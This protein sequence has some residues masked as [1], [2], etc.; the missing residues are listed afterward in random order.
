MYA[1]VDGGYNWWRCLQRLLK[2]DLDSDVKAWSRRVSAVRKD[3]ERAL[4]SKKARTT[5][6]GRAKNPKQE[7]P[8]RQDPP[9][10]P[11]QTASCLLYTS[12][13]ADE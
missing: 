13:A 1:I 10:R 9:P 4:L 5:K 8:R 12:D 6:R 2:D 7:D 11:T 3:V